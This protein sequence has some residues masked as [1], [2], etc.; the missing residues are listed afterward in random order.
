MGGGDGDGGDGSDCWGVAM[1]MVVTVM[2]L[3]VVVVVMMDLGNALA[4]CCTHFLS[5]QVRH[6]WLN[7]SFS[8]TFLAVCIWFRSGTIY[9]LNEDR[10][11]GGGTDETW[12]TPR[13]LKDVAV[14]DL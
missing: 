5:P 13:V 6:Q 11:K 3:E 9:T 8:D 10:A 2:V 7:E 12:D 4:S 14:E 1:V